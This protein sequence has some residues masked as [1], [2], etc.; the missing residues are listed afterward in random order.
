ML[1]VTDGSETLAELFQVGGDGH[2]PPYNLWYA[3]ILAALMLYFFDIVARK[4][5][6][7]EQWLGRFAGRLP[8]M[9]CRWTARWQR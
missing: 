5:P 3:L 4:L 2:R 7:A 8:T 6:P 9:A 1:H